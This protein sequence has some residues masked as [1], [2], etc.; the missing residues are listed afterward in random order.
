[1]SVRDEER[2]IK[3]DRCREREKDRIGRKAA[4]RERRERDGDE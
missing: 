4:D 3:L 1:M 2:D